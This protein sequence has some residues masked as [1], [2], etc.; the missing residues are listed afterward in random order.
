MTEVNSVVIMS[1]NKYNTKKYIGD[2]LAIDDI[3]L[4]HYRFWYKENFF[5]E[6]P[7]KWILS[8]IALLNDT[9][10]GY[11]IVSAHSS[12]RAHIHRMS[13]H[14]QFRR[15]GVGAMLIQHVFV[16]AFREGIVDITLE[17]LRDNHAANRFY[18]KLGFKEL[19]RGEI[20]QYLDEKDKMSKSNKYYA[21]NNGGNRRVFSIKIN[22]FKF[23]NKN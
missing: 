17:S 2:I 18:E 11:C 3:G 9:S 21:I 7:K 23:N 4:G 13:I 8:K 15:T 20:N 6:L 22:N 19:N 14:P 10:L 1:L 16:E 12:K 5:L